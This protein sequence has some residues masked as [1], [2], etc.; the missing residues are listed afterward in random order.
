MLLLFLF[1]LL[2]F[3]FVVGLFFGFVFLLLFFFCSCCFV[4]VFVFFDFF[5]GF[6][7]QVRWPEGPPHLA[8][9]PPY[10]LFVF[11]F[12]GFC[13]FFLCFPFLFFSIDKKTCFPPKKGPFLFIFSVSLSF[14]L[15]FFVLPPFIPF[16]VLCLS[17]VLFFLPSC[18]SFYLSGS[19]FFFLLCLL[20]C[21]KMFFCF[22]FFCLLSCVVL[23]HNISFLFA[24]HLVFLLLLFFVLLALF[25]WY[26][27]ILGNQS[28]NISEK[29]GNSKQQKSKM[30]KKTD[31]L[32]RTVSTIV[33]TNSVFFCFF[34]FFQFCIFLL[35][36]Q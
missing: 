13:F 35:K 27:L 15:A 11:V 21:F 3:C 36:T 17:L 19:C 34:C 20:F 25:F 18:F 33:F 4:L 8:L 23:N 22:C 5:G 31:I 28:K 6:K 26:F 16:L 9:N 29:H 1:C 2:C 7:G 30:Q 10:F 32:T 12:F 24:L 14:S